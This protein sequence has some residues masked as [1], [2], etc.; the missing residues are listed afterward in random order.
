MLVSSDNDGTSVPIMPPAMDVDA[1]L[2]RLKYV[3]LNR[4]LVAGKT[5]VFS[6]P[7][8]LSL[9]SMQACLVSTAFVVVLGLTISSRLYRSYYRS[10]M[11]EDTKQNIVLKYKTFS[12][13]LAMLCHCQIVGLLLFDEGI[14]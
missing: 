14:V 12:L 8:T 7:F 2:L 13:P 6:K 9:S 4:Y 3:A 11:A 1:I 5:T 10:L